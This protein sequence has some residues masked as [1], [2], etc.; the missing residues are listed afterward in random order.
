MKRRVGRPHH[1]YSHFLIDVYVHFDVTHSVRADVTYSV[2][3][4][5]VPNF[6]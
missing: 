6:S 3:T 4:E 2:R 1:P 5:P